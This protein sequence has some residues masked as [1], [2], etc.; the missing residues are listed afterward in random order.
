MNTRK[1]NLDGLEIQGEIGASKYTKERAA[2]RKKRRDSHMSVQKSSKRN[3]STGA[4]SM[5]AE[6][7]QSAKMNRIQSCENLKNHGKT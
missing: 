7:K 6:E 1:I 5:G 4:Q 3:K 2:I